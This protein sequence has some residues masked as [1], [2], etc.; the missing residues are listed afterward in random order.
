[1]KAKAT[2]TSPIFDPPPHSYTVESCRD[3][4]G[5]TRKEGKD[6]SDEADFLQEK[7][8]SK[9]RT[10]ARSEYLPCSSGLRWS[11]IGLAAQ[12]GFCSGPVLRERLL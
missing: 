10:S 11:V 12:D 2:F 7:R 9:E 5:R 1:M 3:Y 6:T 4:G 8:T